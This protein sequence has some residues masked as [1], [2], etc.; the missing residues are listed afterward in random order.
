MY[1]EPSLP[2]GLQFEAG[3]PRSGLDPAAVAQQPELSGNAG[4]ISALAIVTHDLRG[5]L[6]NLSVLMELI[7]A[8]AEKRAFDEMPA[9]LVQARAVIETLDQM[10]A[11]LLQRTRA[12]GDPLGFSLSTINLSSILQNALAS[13]LPLAEKRAVRLHFADAGPIAV[14]GDKCLLL[15][16]F[17]NILNNAV[18]HS[19]GGTT[20]RCIL[21]ADDDNVMV[22]IRD[23]GPGLSTIDLKRAFRPFTTL[24]SRAKHA[25]CSFGLGLWICKLIIERHRGHIDAAAREDADGAEFT[26]RL[27]LA[28]AQ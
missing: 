26:I 24:S 25:A 21:D 19:P 7:E 8:Y 16:V 13:N 2:G 4:L 27:P 22:R 14:L 20:V 1:G 28:T 6:A 18:K 11:A 17:E 5:P 9:R 12:T 23:Q 10:L 15:Q 3:I